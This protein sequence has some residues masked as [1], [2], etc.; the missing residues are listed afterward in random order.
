MPKHGFTYR[1]GCSTFALVDALRFSI[2]ACFPAPVADVYGLDRHATTRHPTLDSPIAWRL[3]DTPSP[4]WACDSHPPC[5]AGSVTTWT[6][7]SFLRGYYSRHASA[8]MCTHP[9]VISPLLPDASQGLAFLNGSVDMARL[10][11]ARVHGVP[12]R[13]AVPGLQMRT[14]A[15]L[16]TGLSG[17]GALP[18]WK[19]ESSCSCRQRPQPYVAPTT[20]S[21]RACLPYQDH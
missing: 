17:N 9:D 11:Q 15:D 18:A 2:S 19:P 5:A 4:H 10:G 8:P 21:H 6:Q 1:N 3:P 13:A 14:S 12:S 7:V 16:R 20:R